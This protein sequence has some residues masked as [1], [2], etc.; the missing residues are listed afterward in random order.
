MG[1]GQTGQGHSPR[2]NVGPVEGLRGQHQANRSY[3]DIGGQDE[4]LTRAGRYSHRVPDG[5]NSGN[6]L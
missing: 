4:H 6:G 1:L 3:V 2:E 5:P